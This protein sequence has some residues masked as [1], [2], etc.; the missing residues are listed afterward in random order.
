MGN[1]YTRRNTLRLQGY[2]YRVA[3]TYFLTL[4]VK[5]REMLFG[6]I[7]HGIM[8]V[9]EF[10]KIVETEW[11][12]TQEIR[13]TVFLDEYVIMPNHVHAIL[14]LND[15]FVGPYT[16]NTPTIG[17]GADGNPPAPCDS[18]VSSVNEKET[19]ARTTSLSNVIAAFKRASTKG[20]NDLRGTRGAEVWQRSFFDR[21]LRNEH[22]LSLARK[23]IFEN[24]IMWEQDNENPDRLI[25]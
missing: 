16:Q 24:P 4:C 25:P 3:G 23:Y 9:N 19:Y 12:R 2:D 13:D 18:N 15:A 20:I 1:N 17:V 14:H 22:E 11:E 8:V 7:E 10:G 6:R 21:V 5:G